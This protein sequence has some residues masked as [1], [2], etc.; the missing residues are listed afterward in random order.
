M[1]AGELYARR[2]EPILVDDRP[3][4]RNRCEVCT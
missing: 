3:K 1:E 4:I 2:I